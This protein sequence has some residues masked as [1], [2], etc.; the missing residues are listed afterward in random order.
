MQHRNLRI[1]WSV[2]W[3][4]LCLALVALEVRSYWC[5]D[6]VLVRGT[7]IMSVDG[8]LRFNELV[9]INTYQPQMVG[10]FANQSFPAGALTPAGVGT[11]LPYTILVALTA[12]MV[13]A[14]LVKWST[15]YN[16]NTLLIAT[17]VVALTLGLAAMQLR[18][19]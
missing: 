4:A 11:P 13:V 3:G 14:P 15:R 16:L 10:I 8:C 9:H 12:A 6:N 1:A 2:A 19:H 18:G 17:A 5:M 7:R